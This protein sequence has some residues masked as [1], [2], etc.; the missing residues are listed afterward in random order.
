MN[1]RNFIPWLS[2]VE[3]PREEAAGLGLSTHY[4]YEMLTVAWFGLGV[5][6]FVR[7]KK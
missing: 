7:V 5:G 1:W 4:R 3:L 2:W 6:F